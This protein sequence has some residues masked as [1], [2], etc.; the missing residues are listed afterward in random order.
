MLPGVR[1]FLLGEKGGSVWDCLAVYVPLCT[2]T[3]S[4]KYCTTDVMRSLSAEHI[5]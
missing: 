5:P 4:P 1:Y 3:F 2:R